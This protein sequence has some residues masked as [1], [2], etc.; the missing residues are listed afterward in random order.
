MRKL[1]EDLCNAA[2]MR[3]LWP[4]RRAAADRRPRS[5][6]GR[7]R[8]Q[9]AMRAAGHRSWHQGIGMPK[10]KRDTRIPNGRLCVPCFLCNVFGSSQCS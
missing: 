9:R 2:R 1:F 10:T 8:R 4:E 7:L 6:V 3:A 5:T